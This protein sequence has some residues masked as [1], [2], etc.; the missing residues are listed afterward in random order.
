MCR[1]HNNYNGLMEVISGL[2]SSA[3]RKLQET[4]DVRFLFLQ[5]YSR[6]FYDLLFCY[7]FPFTN[8]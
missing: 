7:Y 8:K 5:H 3:A 4:W 1:K 2:N 6:C